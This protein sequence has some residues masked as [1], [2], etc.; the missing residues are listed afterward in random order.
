MMPFIVEHDEDPIETQF[1]FW[2]E[3]YNKTS[4]SFICIFTNT[5]DNATHISLSE[6]QEYVNALHDGAPGIVNI[7]KN[8]LTKI[9][10]KTL[11]DRFKVYLLTSNEP[12]VLKSRLTLLIP[13]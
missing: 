3:L 10:M 4:I 1:K 13:H 9:G 8:Y 6:V 7:K 12:Y 11:T 2:S 5:L